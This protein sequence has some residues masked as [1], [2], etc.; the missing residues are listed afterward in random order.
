MS[1]DKSLDVSSDLRPSV[2]VLLG[3]YHILST[4]TATVVCCT[5]IFCAMAVLACSKR[6]LYC[7]GY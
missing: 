1:L 7:C 2:K 5:P 3:P 4:A 6:F